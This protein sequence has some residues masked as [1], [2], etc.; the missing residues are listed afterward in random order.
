MIPTEF[1]D[2]AAE[3]AR[4]L[5]SSGCRWCVCMFMAEFV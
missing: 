5:S 4:S 2:I 3:F 1:E